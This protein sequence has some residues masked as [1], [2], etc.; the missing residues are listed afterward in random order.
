MGNNTVTHSA[1]ADKAKGHSK[2]TVGKIREKVGEFIGD[3]EMQAKGAMQR[4]DGKKDQAKGEI[5][6]AVED[7]KN[8]FKAGVEIV[9]EKLPQGRGH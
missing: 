4:A 7:V 6:E 2:Q 1:A 9:K 3:D 5:K 8:K